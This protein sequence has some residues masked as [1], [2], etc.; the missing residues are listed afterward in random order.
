MADAKVLSNQKTILSNQ[1][2]IVKNQ[3]A[4]LGQSTLDR[5][6]SKD[7]LVEPGR[8]QE[9]PG[10]TRGN[11]EKSEADTRRLSQVEDGLSKTSCVPHCLCTLRALAWATMKSLLHGSSFSS[12]GS[13]GNVR[14]RT[15]LRSFS[16][17]IQCVSHP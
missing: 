5:E 7:H 13:V 9:E 14:H 16:S 6:K 10:F 8:H 15:K 4:I 17:R 11:P 2:T 3:K 1:G 12:F